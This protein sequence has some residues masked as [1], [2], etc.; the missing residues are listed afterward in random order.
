MKIVLCVLDSFGIGEAP[1]ASLYGDL[2]SNTYKAISENINIP[3]LKRLGLNNIDGIDF[4]EKEINPIGSYCRLI[5]LS[6]GKDTTTGHFEIAGLISKNFAPTY[7]NGFPQNI[8]DQLED[9]FKT[10]I[11]GNKACS[12]TIIINEL[13]DK[14]NETGYPI[15]YT[16]A[17]SV[18]QIACDIKKYSVDELYDMC[19]KA[20]N[21]MVG[22][23]AVDRI[24]A[25]PFTKD[26]STGKYFRTKDRKDFGLKPEKD[27][28]LNILQKNNIKVV[29][30]GKIK[31]I[32]SMSGIDIAIEAHGNDEVMHATIECMKNYDNCLIFSNFIDFDMEYGHRND[33]LGYKK[34]LEKF[35]KSLEIIMDNLGNN[36][37][38]IITADHGCD[39]STE[40]T[41]HSRETVPLLIYNKKMR[42]KNYGIKEGYNYISGTILNKF[43]IKSEWPIL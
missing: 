17:D 3:N 22:D 42:S 26:E 36:D 19:K 40:S 23:Y 30:V 6:K 20:R 15:V 32:F 11:I 2:G 14:H 12:G 34:A 10:K 21:I 1:D 5:E 35:D 33:V 28:M 31:D 13:G 18:L 39:P 4:V 43:G 16:S 24:I 9:A 41:D 7:P 27:T 8:V 37:Y 29:S 25:R 38:L